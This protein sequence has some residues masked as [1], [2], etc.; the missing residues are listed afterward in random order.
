ML[1]VVVVAPRSA[2]GYKA[3]P[4]K[5]GNYTLTYSVEYSVCNSPGGAG[6]NKINLT[7]IYRNGKLIEAETPLGSLPP[8]AFG[9]PHMLGFY[10]EI[11]SL[12]GV[13]SNTTLRFDRGTISKSV[14]H[15]NNVRLIGSPYE[16]H[17][18]VE[19]VAHVSLTNFTW[20]GLAMHFKFINA[21]YIVVK[22]GITGV[23]VYFTGVLSDPAVR[24]A[25]GCDITTISISA[26]L[27]DVK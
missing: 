18:A 15:V 4:T 12:N 21:N 14:I 24:K 26:Y 1:I 7:L 11:I 3:I 5:G 2:G 19:I 6:F 23:P 22:D 13:L 10:D 8:S 20:P 17:N 16:A 9:F 27:I 25:F